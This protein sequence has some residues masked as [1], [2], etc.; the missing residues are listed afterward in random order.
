MNR[1]YILIPMSNCPLSDVADRSNGNDHRVSF[2]A[3]RSAVNESREA[4][5][6]R[7]F[8][9]PCCPPWCWP[10]YCWPP[11]CGLWYFFDIGKPFTRHDSWQLTI[12][13]AHCYH[14]VYYR[15]CCLVAINGAIGTGTHSFDQFSV[16]HLTIWHPWI[17]STCARRSIACY[18]FDLKVGPQ[19]RSSGNGR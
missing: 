11:H 3:S 16:T 8:C 18:C 12:I 17:S 4:G 10:Q 13:H 14:H 5:G 15:A 1:G 9:P 7:Y 2:T 6:K 19:Y